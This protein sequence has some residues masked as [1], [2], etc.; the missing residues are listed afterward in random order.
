VMCE[1]PERGAALSI[2]DFGI[3]LARDGERLGSSIK[4]K[5]LN[6]MCLACIMNMLSI[7]ALSVGLF[8]ERSSLV[9][10][11]R[12]PK[13]GEEMSGGD[14]FQATGMNNERSL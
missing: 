14:A 12:N 7:V 3:L 13:A 2:A 1:Q 11:D 4:K 10:H 8:R 9:P 6:P 5:S